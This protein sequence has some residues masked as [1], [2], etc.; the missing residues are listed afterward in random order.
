MLAY[1]FW[2]WPAEGADPDGYARDLLA[3]HDALGLPG[4]H[5]VRLRRAPFDDAPSPVFEDWYPVA[6]WAA[7]GELNERAVTGAR[8]GPHD[9]AA[10]HA[11]GGAGAIYRRLTEDRPSQPLACAAWLH[12]PAGRPYDEF[13]PELTAT[14]ATVWQRQLVLG[15]APEFVLLS[16]EPLS[17]SWP[18]IS[19][20][21]DPLG[22]A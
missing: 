12:K 3:F 14:G 21:P 7:I 4:S 13:L 5:S 18:A 17:L 16:A 6:G 8:R 19:T 2:H 15:P 1:L 9:Q 11:A 10:A 20:E 22:P